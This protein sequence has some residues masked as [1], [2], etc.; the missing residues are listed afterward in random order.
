MRGVLTG[1]L[2]IWSVTLVGY[3]VGRYGLL[4]P[5]G[6]GV[7]ARLVFLIATPA[8]LFSTLARST[9]AGLVTPALAAF[10]LSTLIVAAV[11]LLVARYAW[12]R[13]TGESVVGALCASYVNAANLGIPVAAYV[14]RDVSVVAPVLIFQVLV[15]APLAL[16]V[17]DLTATGR[18]PS[19]RRLALLPARNP[20]M[21]GCAAGLAVAVSGWHPP[22]EVMRPFELVGSAAVPLALLALGMALPGSRP[23]AGT[24]AD[25]PRYVAVALKVVVQPAL[26]YLLARFLLGLTG[27]ALLAAV[28][29]SALPTAQNVFVFATHFRQA[30]TLA[31]DA[32]VLSTVAAAVSLVMI[33]GWLA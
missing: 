26:A 16:A 3:L 10:V 7:V 9:V 28:V 4:G 27:P 21:L 15:A 1:F 17:L 32:V 33:A 18:R 14:L 5:E 12:R 2:V 24:T 19:L 13:T 22:A 23:L 31:R 8:L 6:T 20:I 25:I 29:T 11:Y 30:Q